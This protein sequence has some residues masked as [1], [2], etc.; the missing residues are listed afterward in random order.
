MF[1]VSVN[2]QVN[3]SSDQLADETNRDDLI[4]F[5]RDICF[6]KVS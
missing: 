4:Q 2:A 5:I 6:C 3:V 1:T